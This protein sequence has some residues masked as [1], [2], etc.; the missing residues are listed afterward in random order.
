MCLPADHICKWVQKFQS[1]IQEL[2]DVPQSGQ[3][4]HIITP[5]SIA[6][7]ECLIWE[8]HCVTLNNLAVTL[9]MSVDLV[10]N[11]IHK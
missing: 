11:L 7:A 10:H 6:E 8:N 5:D 2:D 9:Q 3:A 4:H 1:G